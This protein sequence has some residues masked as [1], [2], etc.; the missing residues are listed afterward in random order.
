VKN[1]FLGS[2]V[3]LVVLVI[4][5]YA[6]RRFG[7]AEVRGD[8]PFSTLESSLMRMA[9]QAS[10]RR[11]APP[12]MNRSRLLKRILLRVEKCIAENVQAATGRREKTPMRPMR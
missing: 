9:L 2:I 6:Y 3:T 1:F 12:L 7:L 8:I 10:A 5:A 4:G 11:N